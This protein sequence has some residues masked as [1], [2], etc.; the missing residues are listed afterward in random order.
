MSQASNGT[1]PHAFGSDASV[2]RAS[3]PMSDAAVSYV[4]LRKQARSIFF[5]CVSFLSICV[6][7]ALRFLALMSSGKPV[8][9]QRL[10][11]CGPH[12]KIFCRRND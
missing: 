2:V 12:A 9:V 8:P 6:V 10:F 3:A 4:K 7:L 5:I 11:D 1:C